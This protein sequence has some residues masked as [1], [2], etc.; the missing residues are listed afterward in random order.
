LFFWLLIIN[1]S[2]NILSGVAAFANAP[3]ALY[4]AAVCTVAMGAIFGYYF[5]LMG[6]IC[7]LT[8]TASYR[9]AWDETVGRSS[10]LDYTSNSGI[11]GALVP[12]FIILMAGL[13][14]LAYNMILA[15][16]TRSLLARVGV[17]VT[18]TECLWATIVCI[19]LPLCMVKKLSVLAPFSLVGLIGMVI[20]IGVI[21]V[22]YY[23]GSYEPPSWQEEDVF[24]TATTN[25]T[26]TSYWAQ[27][28]PSL[29]PMF[30]TVG[31]IGALSGNFLILACMNFQG[32]FCHYNAPRYY[33]ELENNTIER[34]TRVVVISFGFC[35]VLY[36]VLMTYGFLTFGENSDGFILNNYAD[37]DNIISVCRLLIA[38]ALAFTYPLPF[39]GVR[40]GILDLLMVPPLKRTSNNLNVLSLVLLGTF[41]FLA[42]HFTDVGM[43]NAIG[44]GALGTA[45]V[46]IFP[47][48]MFRNIVQDLGIH[49]PVKLNQ[50]ANF[51]IGLMWA[52]IA[53][54]GVGVYMGIAQS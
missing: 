44:G 3:S 41:G 29:Q 31:A 49:A 1:S 51:A 11:M 6:R 53:M 19:L 54:G 20:T 24:N 38:I 37:D 50:E 15:D 23:D 9:E 40:D 22:R 13:G 48:L 43:V 5:L 10:S 16:T 42:M 18:R 36:V 26:T 45:V 47:A 21:V 30:G 46:F 28:P 2:P 4:P 34:F 39:I 52:G 12:L 27:V 14:N 8:A 25:T 35:M 33:I 17:E 32:F 7:Q